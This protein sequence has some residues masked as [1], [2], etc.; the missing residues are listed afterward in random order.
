M[1]KKIMSIVSIALLS[2]MCVATITMSLIKVNQNTEIAMP[3][4]VYITNFTTEHNFERGAYKLRSSK[5]A[6]K[7]K[8]TSLYNALCRGFEQSC[9]ISL[10]R[11]ELSQKTEACY[12][13]PAGAT[14]TVSKNFSSTDRFTVYFYYDTP[15]LIKVGDRTFGYQYV[16]FEVLPVDARAQVTFAVNDK[17]SVD[18]STES[19]G[20]VSTYTEYEYNF[21]AFVNLKGVHELLSTWDL[22]A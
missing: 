10:F 9:F 22:T 13:H 6:D 12:D 8:I 1:I 19:T 3:Q 14:N 5:E 11:G 20:E 4:D 15:R 21:K 7:E 17:N 2:L 16:F 18:V